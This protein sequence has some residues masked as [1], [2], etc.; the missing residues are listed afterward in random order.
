M[1]SFITKAY[2][3]NIDVYI[4]YT[5]ASTSA[6]DVNARTIANNVSGMSDLDLSII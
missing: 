4:S 1:S 3:L 2:L 6:M 5:V